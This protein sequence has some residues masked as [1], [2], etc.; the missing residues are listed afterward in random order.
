MEVLGSVFLWFLG[1]Y[2]KVVD[3]AVYWSA[4]L[5]VV[6]LKVVSV[7]VHWYNSSVFPCK[8]ECLGV[9]V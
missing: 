8:V 6:A 1:L 9:I 7:T 3:V 4:F 5:W 2:I